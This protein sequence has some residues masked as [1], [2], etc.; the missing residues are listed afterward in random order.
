MGR[1][2]KHADGGTGLIYVGDILDTIDIAE[3]STPV[4]L[5]PWVPRE[6]HWQHRAPRDHRS[7]TVTVG[8]LGG[9]V[10]AVALILL[11]GSAAPSDTHNHPVS[12]TTTITINPTHR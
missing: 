3:A 8:I 9:F 7:E 5:R 12:T 10:I 6:G 1:H 2:A 11:S 4:T